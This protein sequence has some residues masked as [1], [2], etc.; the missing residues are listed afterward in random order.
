VVTFTE[1]QSF[2]IVA[3]VTQNVLSAEVTEFRVVPSTT[4]P[5]IKTFDT[6]HFIYVNREIVVDH[7]KG[8]PADRG[9]LLL[10]LTGTGGKASECSAFCKLAA[11]EGYHVISLMYPDEIPA[12]VCRNDAD[13]KA[14]EEFRLA[15]IQGGATKHITIDQPESIE[16]RL[17]HLLL[18]LRTRR[19]RENWDL[20]TR[21]GGIKWES[22]V[23]AGQSQG[24]GHA[25]LIG[26]RYRVERVIC[27]GAPKDY[28][29]RLKAPAAW[30]GGE[31]A[32]SKNR[33]FA[34]N[35]RQDPMGCTPEQLLS[36]LHALK[37]DLFGDP[38]DV[39]TEKPPYH[40]T[41]ILI[42]SYPRVSITD[43]KSALEAHTSVISNKNEHRMLSVWLYMLTENSD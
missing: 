8:L 22:I 38:V 11:N 25:A 17:M 19:P 26:I 12:T 10:W 5:R 29:K 28:S 40:H 37:L 1:I 21:D 16:S 43:E 2:T 35:H 15:I 42:T 4:D 18:A 14:F 33:F 31:S 41:R 20:F 23:V 9:Q 39:A 30:Y 24:G 7:K 32:T 3:L 34:F 13:P 6:P 36:N 27:T